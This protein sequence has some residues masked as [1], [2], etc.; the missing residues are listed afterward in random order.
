MSRVVQPLTTSLE[1]EVSPPP[2][3]PQRLAV[4]STL[5]YASMLP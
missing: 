4:F 3:L 1:N 5:I 2:F